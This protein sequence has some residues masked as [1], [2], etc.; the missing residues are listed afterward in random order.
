[1]AKFSPS[2]VIMVDDSQHPIVFRF[3][4]KDFCEKPLFTGPVGI[5]ILMII[6]MILGQIGKY[7][8]IEFAVMNSI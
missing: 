1:M 5:H 8:E 7:C 3:D 4:V 6:Q 2:F